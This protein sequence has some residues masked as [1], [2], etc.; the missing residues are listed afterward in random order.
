MVLPWVLFVALTSFQSPAEGLGDLIIGI[1]GCLAVAEDVSFNEDA[2]FLVVAAAQRPREVTGAE[3]TR[4]GEGSDCTRRWRKELPLKSRAARVDLPG[5]L[6][7][8][9]IFVIPR[10]PGLRMFTGPPTKLSAQETE[11]LL[12]VATPSVPTSWKRKDV[13]MHAYR[14]GPAGGQAA[15]ELYIGR[16]TLN[17][18]GVRP[19]I[20]AISIRRV[21]LVAGRVLASEE[22]ERVSGREERVDTEPP[23]LTFVN[24]S[25][26][27]TERT[28]AFVSTDDGASWRRLSTD[29]GFEGINWVAQHLR[30]GLPADRWFLYTPH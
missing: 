7:R 9:A 25:V 21:F 27:D 19:P 3:L 15:V 11:I 1:H 5:T 13:L 26:S 29:V 2:R 12:G 23:H 17:P 22:Y 18:R 24:W 14:Y 4:P 8:E 6:S 20:K 16:A 28:V 10:R 30:D